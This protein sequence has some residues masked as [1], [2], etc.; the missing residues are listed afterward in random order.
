MSFISSASLFNLLWSHHVSRSKCYT[1]WDGTKGSCL[2]NVPPSFLS[3]P[4]MSKFFVSFLKFYAENKPRIVLIKIHTITMIK[5]FINWKSLY[6]SVIS[7]HKLNFI[8]SQLTLENF[9]F[10]PTGILFLITSSQYRY[11]F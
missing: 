4:C 2:F 11:I 1:L 6:L 7:I 8:R 5:K 9:Y 10:V 3:V